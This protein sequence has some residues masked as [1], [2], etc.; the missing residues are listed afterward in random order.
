MNIEKIKFGGQEYDLVPNGVSLGTTGGTV[1]FQKGTQSFD[2]IESVLMGTGSITLIGLSGEPEWTRADLRYTGKLT[3]QSKYVV[4]IEQTETGT[5][6][7]TGEPVYAVTDIK[8]DVMVAEFKAPDL[9]EEL[10]ATKAKLEYVA[11]M[12]G[13]D[14]EEV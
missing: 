1:T 2:E 11:M 9:A 6:E 3:K 5:D 4:G 8:G 13:I 12:S 7:E 10:A 14:L